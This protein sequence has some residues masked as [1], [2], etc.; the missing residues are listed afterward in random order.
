MQTKEGP[1]LLTPAAVET[2]RA[3]APALG[4]RRARLPMG[5]AGQ[6][7]A[8][9]VR[10]IIVLAERFQELCRLRTDPVRLVELLRSLIVCTREAFVGGTPGRR[11]RRG[12]GFP[13]VDQLRCLDDLELLLQGLMRGAPSASRGLAHAMDSLLIQCVIFEAAASDASDK[14]DPPRD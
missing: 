12:T 10:R 3:A 1:S 8:M 4:G 7:P 11:G 9:Q 14:A 2:G 5:L 13:S 6:I